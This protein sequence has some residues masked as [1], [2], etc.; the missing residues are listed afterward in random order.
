MDLICCIG[1]V[2]YIYFVQTDLRLDIL[3]SS[4]VGTKH[5]LFLY[6]CICILANIQCVVVTRFIENLI[7]EFAAKVDKDEDIHSRLRFIYA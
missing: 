4:L 3:H 5:I 7:H 1:W 6:I 2:D